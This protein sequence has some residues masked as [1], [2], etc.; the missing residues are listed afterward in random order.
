[1]NR[2][3]VQQIVKKNLE[4]KK[5]SAKMVSQILTDDQKQRRLYISP[6]VLHNAE[7]F[8]RVITSVETWCFQYDLEAK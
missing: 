8:D 7:M 4:I 1:V 6:D 2:E 3:T 5:I